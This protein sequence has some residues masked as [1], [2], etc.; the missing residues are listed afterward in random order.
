MATVGVLAL[1]GDFEAHE[2][3]LRDLGHEVRRVKAP[4]HLEGIEALV[5]PGGESS[6]MLKLAALSG[7]TEPLAAFCKSGAPVLG[8]CAGAILL[9]SEVSGPEQTSLGV[10]DIGVERNGYGRQLES[11]V[12]RLDGE[13]EALAD[14]ECV[15]IR[16]PVIRRVGAG[17]EVL[18]THAELPVLVRA[19][20]VWAATFH[21]ELGSDPRLLRCVLAPL[22]A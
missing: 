16:A 20:P 1:Q 17:V 8:T 6:S 9:A 3:A 18:A 5:L 19:G 14:L 13:D 12:T 10:L 22:D 7:L 2:R 21:P 11:F 15:F 4:E